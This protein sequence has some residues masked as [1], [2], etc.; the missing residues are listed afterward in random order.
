M[1]KRCFYL[2]YRRKRSRR[3]I[4]WTRPTGGLVMEA[5]GYVYGY[6]ICDFQ[7][8]ADVLHQRYHC[9]PHE[10]LIIAEVL[11]KTEKG[12]AMRLHGKW[13]RDMSEFMDLMEQNLA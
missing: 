8:A 10:E 13:E 6:P 7:L 2:A 1:R 9:G 4:D 11:E 3:S 5:D 12:I